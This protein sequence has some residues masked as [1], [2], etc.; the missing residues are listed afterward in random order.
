MF[1]RACGGK[2]PEDS[3]FC[4]HCG[5]RLQPLSQEAT[6]V[7]DPQTTQAQARQTLSPETSPLLSQPFQAVP[8]KNGEEREEED[9][10][11][12]PLAPPEAPASGTVPTVQ[13]TLQV[14]TVPSIPGGAATAATASTAATMAK[15]LL[16]AATCAAVIFAGM[17]AAPIVFHTQTKPS[18][19]QQIVTSTSP[20]PTPDFKPFVGV[21]YAHAQEMTIN[22]N[23]I[24]AMSCKFWN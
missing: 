14:G 23:G 19:I 7:S 16:I 24:L 20:T 2:S 22:T 21:W 11:L 13:G 10:V 12:P 4:A 3:L 5:Y 1:C 18:S 9:R 15:V 6:P 8:T 17:K